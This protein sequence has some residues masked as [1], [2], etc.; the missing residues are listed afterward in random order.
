LPAPAASFIHSFL[1]S[2]ASHQRQH[3]VIR[4]KRRPRAPFALLQPAAANLVG[5]GAISFLATHAPIS[6]PRQGLL[7]RIR[8]NLDFGAKEKSEMHSTLT[9][10]TS[11][12]MRSFCKDGKNDKW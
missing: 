7:K 5:L 2:F 11:I 1:R 12:H 3:F 8:M 4:L 6:K 10:A 9:I